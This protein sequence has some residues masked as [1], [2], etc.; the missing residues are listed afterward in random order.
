MLSRKLWFA[1][2]YKKN[3]RDL[4]SC[5]LSIKFR[6]KFDFLDLNVIILYY[7]AVSAAV[8]AEFEFLKKIMMMHESTR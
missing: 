4:K 3:Y 1:R 5:N 8:E 2:N 6:L 7:S